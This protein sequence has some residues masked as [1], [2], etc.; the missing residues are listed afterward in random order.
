MSEEVKEKITTVPDSE[1][2]QD[3]L[4]KREKNRANRAKK[5]AK[6]K[7]KIDL[8][9]EQPAQEKKVDRR[10]SYEEREKQQL[11]KKTAKIERNAK[12]S[13]VIIAETAEARSLAFKVDEIN[14][15]TDFTRSFMGTDRVTFSVG[16]ELI[17]MFNHKILGNIDEFMA[18]AAKNNIGS[19]WTLD[20]YNK[21]QK[22]I[23]NKIKKVA[24]KRDRFISNENSAEKK[25]REISEKLL[26][27][28]KSDVELA[29]ENFIKSLEA[30]EKQKD[31]LDQVSKTHADQFIDSISM[32]NERLKAENKAS[33]NEAETKTI[34]K[35]DE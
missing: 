10:P 9:T 4:K 33:D 28:A 35:E 32:Q 1:L 31:T 24:E 17:E 3:Q 22:Y 34:T 27:K 20:E 13:V 14:R 18:L 11:D 15:I 26:D 12:G 25:A 19:R 30:L 5:K 6:D 23:N 7:S 29:Q 8:A 21:E 2:S 16:Q